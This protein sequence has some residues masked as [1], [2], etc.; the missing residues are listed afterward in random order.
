MQAGVYHRQDTKLLKEKK[1]VTEPYLSHLGRN[2]FGSKALSDGGAVQLHIPIAV[3]DDMVR[4]LL[5]LV[6]DFAHLASDEPLH[7]EESVFRVYN[8][9]SLCNLSNKP[10][11]I[12][13]IRDYG[14]CGSLPLRIRHDSRLSTFHRCHGGV[15]S[16]EVNPH[17]FLRYNSQQR[18]STILLLPAS[19]PPHIP[20]RR[21]RFQ[22]QSTATETWT[23]SQP[24][25]KERV[26]A[27]CCHSFLVCTFS[28]QIPGKA[29]LHSQANTQNLR[30]HRSHRHRFCLSTE[31][32]RDP[33]LLPLRK[34]RSQKHN[35]IGRLQQ[36]QQQLCQ[37]RTRAN[38]KWFVGSARLSSFSISMRLPLDNEKFSIA[39]R[40]S[41]AD[42]IRSQTMLRNED[43]DDDVFC[44]F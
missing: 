5:G 27:K 43:D 19:P 2:F 41:S 20:L 30:I 25:A 33:S 23:A 44:S 4:D 8:R 17:H 24:C 15:G 39:A 21:S 37:K 16:P 40:I 22:P 1:I 11:A 9:L 14:R 36:Q 32:P 29:L 12:L 38:K 10:V 3:A 28:Y 42:L 35:A 7:G 13:G 34:L 31:N 6:I 26:A 18:A